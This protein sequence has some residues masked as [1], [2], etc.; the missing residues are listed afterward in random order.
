MIHYD[1]FDNVADGKKRQIPAFYYRPNKENS[2]KYPVLIYIHG[3]PESQYQPNFTWRLQYFAIELGI[4]VIVPN[5]IVYLHFF[6]RNN[7]YFI[8][9]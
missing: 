2:E 4:A 9:E 8:N 1:T 5:V 7:Y 3:G 6:M